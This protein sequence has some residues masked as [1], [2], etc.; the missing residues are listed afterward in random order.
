MHRITLELLNIRLA[1]CGFIS[2]CVDMYS[3]S[4]NVCVCG[5]FCKYESGCLSNITVVL[6][7]KHSGCVLVSFQ[8][9]YI[10]C[11]EVYT[12]NG[13]LGIHLHILHA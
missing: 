7:Q 1:L 9:V 11:Y 8:H 5:C 13:F 12:I 4:G 10:S 6:S 2:Q 3:K